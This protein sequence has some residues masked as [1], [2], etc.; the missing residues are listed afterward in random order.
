MALAAIT[1]ETLTGHPHRLHWCVD[2]DRDIGPHA[3]TPA[4]PL[5]AGS[6][7]PRWGELLQRFRNVLDAHP[8]TTPRCR[9]ALIVNHRVASSGARVQ[10]VWHLPWRVDLPW[11]ARSVPPVG[12]WLIAPEPPPATSGPNQVELDQRAGDSTPADQAYWG[13]VPF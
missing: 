2:L 6:V 8:S 13:A 1:L 12:Q 11:L 10:T 5:D 7:D 3:S 9:L 4:D